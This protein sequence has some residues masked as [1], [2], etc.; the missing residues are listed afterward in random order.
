MRSQ[1]TPEEIV[2][3]KEVL[4]LMSGEV[5]RA[6]KLILTYT[7]HA[8]ECEDWAHRQMC[9][10]K[11]RALAA[12]LIDQLRYVGLLEAELAK[13]RVFADPLKVLADIERRQEKLLRPA[14][15][16]PMEAMANAPFTR[17]VQ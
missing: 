9:M 2:A 16:D 6:A 11:T 15:R 13:T 10:A 7:T 3:L 4:R 1:Y 8:G 5:D 17:A 14:P 12:A